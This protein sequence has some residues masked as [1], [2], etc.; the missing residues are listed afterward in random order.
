M[1]YW[2]CE[3]GSKITAFLISRFFWHSL[4]LPT[5]HVEIACLV[6]VFVEVRCS[7]SILIALLPALKGV[8]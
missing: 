7:M 2:E 6:E 8:Y 3:N 4:N 1:W 5:I